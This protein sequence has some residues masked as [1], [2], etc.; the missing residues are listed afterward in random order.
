M[1]SEDRRILAFLLAFKDLPGIGSK[2]LQ[3]LIIQYGVEILAAE[4]LDADFVC[5]LAEGRFASA[6]DK[7]EATWE[8][9]EERAFAILDDSDEKGISVLDPFMEAYP[10]RLL[11]YSQRLPKPPSFPPIL[12]VRGNVDALN[13]KKAVA[14]VGTRQP[15]EFGAQMGERLAQLLSED[16]YVIVSGLA[17]GCDT[18]G[19]EGALKAGGLTIATMATSIDAPV[20]PKQN[21]ELAERILEMGGALVSEYAPGLKIAE[22]QLAGNLVARDEWQ[23]ALS[24]GIIAVESSVDGGTRHALKHAWNAKIPIAVF[25]YSSRKTV[26]FEGDSRFSGNVHC[27]RSMDASPIFAPETIEAF[28]KRMDAY[29]A[30]DADAGEPAVEQAQEPDQ[31]HLSFSD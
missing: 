25:D 9:L 11:K 2:T 13:R 18:A 10:N 21:R 30:G 1:T 22:R 12:F 8:E 17:I 28:K 16:G 29:R 15:T 6:L 27:L 23:P 19:H 4:R 7:S 5:R 31:L 20:Y 24:D 14:M 3:K 26:D